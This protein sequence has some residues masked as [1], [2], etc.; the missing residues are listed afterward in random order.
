[1]KN[2]KRNPVERFCALLLA[3]IM[4]F[5]LVLPDG[6]LSVS[7]AGNNSDEASGEPEASTEKTTDVEFTIFEKVPTTENPD[8]KVAIQG[9]DLQIKEAGT[10]NV[11][12]NGQSDA[13]GKV[14]VENLTYDTEKSYEYTVSK[15]GYQSLENKSVSIG[16]VNEVEVTLEMSDISLG[17]LSAVELSPNKEGVPSQVQ[18]V[19][20]NKID[21]FEVGGAAQ[22]KWESSNPAV[23]DVDG[24]G[25]I[26]AKGRGSATITVS[27]NGKSAQTTIK[28]KEVPSM[29]LN[30]T[31]DNG[32]DVK[33]VTMTVTMPKD[34]K[35]GKV[36]FSLESGESYEVAV[37]EEG[38]AE[39]VLAKD[40]I[41]NVKVSAAYS[42]NEMYFENSTEET[43]KYKQK[44]RISLTADG[45]SEASITYGSDLPVLSV[46]NAEDRTVTFSSSKPNVVE[47]TP[48]GVLT[49]KGTGRTDITATAAE[50]DNYTE[51]S[52][53]FT[54]KVNQKP[55]N[56]KITFADFEWNVEKASKVY[57]G[58]DK[59]QMTGTLKNA[60][61]ID[62]VQ[63]T[64]N[65]QLE[66]S[67]V[68]SYSKFTV[69]DADS[70]IKLKGANN[71]EIT[72]D[73]SEKE[74]QLAK[75]KTVNITPRPVYIKTAVK[76]GKTTKFA[77]GT[78]K[79]DL[80]KAVE[81][82]Y[83]VVLA[84]TKGRIDETQR[85]GLIKED[86]IN[87]EDYAKV[88]LAGLNKETVYYVGKYKS[89][90]VPVV[91][92]KDAGNYEVT[93]VN[94]DNLAKYSSDLTIEKEKETQASLN[95]L[96]EIV[97]ADGIYQN[98]GSVYIR[99]N[100]TA[101]LK[102]EFKKANAYY[103]QI[104]VSKGEK[105]ADG[106]EIYYDAINSGISFDDSK[107]KEY[108]LKVSLRNSKNALT[109]TDGVEYQKITVDATS[110]TA[111]FKDLG[112]AGQFNK[113]LPND[114]K[115][116]GNFSKDKIKEYLVTSDDATSKV[117]SL[118]TC[119]ITVDNDDA[120]AIV[121]KISEAVKNDSVWEEKDIVQFNKEGNYIVLALV[122]DNVGNK[123]VYASNGLVFD[124]TAPD[125][126][127]KIIEP[128]E[129]TGCNQKVNFT[130]EINDKDITSG[131]D[132]IEVI[133]MD[134]DKDEDVTAE[135]IETV[136]VAGG[137]D[138]DNK[139]VIDSCTLNSEKINTIVGSEQDGTLQSI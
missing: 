41:G 87:L 24:N 48:D 95:E 33:S 85:Q 104:W 80:Q 26:T 59:I 17:D 103:D 44:K 120:E 77:Y 58:N 16:T 89:E 111:D 8:N 126:S 39:Q 62:E 40:L 135:Y 38:I 121:D 4:V 112:N 1:M 42:G 52:A 20:N 118:K 90:V 18:A 30:V 56:K 76:K 2:P 110:P 113:V 5:T 69:T 139:M 31:P 100:E 7:A 55:I 131:V 54:I 134:S 123:A 78:S 83:E 3:F 117:K 116:F 25:L 29:E 32:T 130:V 105:Q 36:T 46:E 128:E 114:W 84:G 107:D 129:N 96:V 49:V 63:V 43:G 14:K 72:T 37:N 15:A 93:V 50:S 53:S 65:A 47:A 82:N 45:K 109:V 9:A 68:G 122:E 99:G 51:S 35:G 34:A 75:G 74:V 73:F 102:L 11:V 127:V 10:D 138:E 6:A 92:K 64:V 115:G 88:E 119:K 19:I 79:A 101:T 21:N 125:V 12:A 13:N 66:K 57:D 61:V 71:Y 106:Q 60:D 22:Y 98:D 94:A 27:R 124:L 91:T 70:D 28:V 67:D 132:K 23:A 108:T 81:E 133:A 137:F 97:G 86:T 136:K